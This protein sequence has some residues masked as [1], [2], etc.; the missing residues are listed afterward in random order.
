MAIMFFGFALLLPSRLSIVMLI[1][2]LIG[3][4]QQAK[5]EETY[6]LRAY[7]DEYRAYARRVGRFS[8]CIGRL[9]D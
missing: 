2:V 8:P 5:T 4:R 7:G 1:G 9:R 6:L 3:I